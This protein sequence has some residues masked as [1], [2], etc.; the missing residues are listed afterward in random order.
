MRILTYVQ[1]RNEVF[2]NLSEEQI[3]RTLTISGRSEEW[4]NKIARLVL[5]GESENDIGII[6]TS[7]MG[8]EILRLVPKEEWVYLINPSLAPEESQVVREQIVGEGRLFSSAL[9]EWLGAQ[10]IGMLY[11]LSDKN[12]TQE[13]A[14]IMRLLWSNQE[15]VCE[16]EDVAA[17]IWGDKWSEKYSDWGI[18]AL[19]SRIRKKISGNWQIVTIKGRG[20]MLASSTKISKAPQTAFGHEELVEEIAGSIYPSDEYLKYMNNP[21]R[22]RKIYGDLFESI[23]REK[24]SINIRSSGK[25][26][27][28]NSYSY[29]NVDIIVDLIKANKWIGTKVYFSHYDPRAVLMHSTRIKELGV[30]SYV[31]SHYDD[32]RESKMRDKTF[33]LVIN[34]FRLNF[35]QNDVQNKSTMGHTLR[36]LKDGGI[37]LV[38]T[39]VDGKYENSR[40]GLDQEKAPINAHKPGM[41]QADEHLVRRCWSVP[42]YRQLFE[43]TGFEEII[44]FDIETG[45]RWGAD[46]V[47][48]SSNPWQGPYYRRWYLKKS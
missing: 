4:L 47:L 5:E 27:C 32:I 26:L 2:Q 10:E 12:F 19:M 14:S 25:I 39:V 33:D 15:S 36:V 43:R 28:V 45:K 21:K 7:G 35:N 41:F 9:A 22:V 40:Y 16:R 30:G 31:E 17:A 23:K 18:D 6:E 42:Y 1:A 48:L 11:K 20:Y 37:A 44:E 46:S 38:S 29:D 34:D 13:E 3:S 24:I 8:R